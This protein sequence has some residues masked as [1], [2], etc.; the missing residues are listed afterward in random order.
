MPFYEEARAKRA[1]N[2]VLQQGVSEQIMELLETDPALGPRILQLHRQGFFDKES[3]ALEEKL[4]ADAPFARGVTHHSRLA[5]RSLDHLFRAL[6][7]QAETVDAICSSSRLQTCRW[8]WCWFNDCE[9]QD[10]L[11]AGTYA[12]LL[13]WSLHRQQAHGPYLCIYAFERI[14]I[15]ICIYV[16]MLIDIY[17]CICSYIHTCIYRHQLICG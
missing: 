10:K 5:L 14:Y 6:G 4:D 16:Y 3:E 1:M 11:P 12:G 15:C 7:L 8:L 9:M 17:V 13:Q 2:E